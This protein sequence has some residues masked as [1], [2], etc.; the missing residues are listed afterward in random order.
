MNI[1]Y[2]SILTD[3][4]S[5]PELISLPESFQLEDSVIYTQLYLDYTLTDA[6]IRDMYHLVYTSHA[7]KQ[8]TDEKLLELLRAIIQR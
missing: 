1:Y 4:A 7:V 5:A 8:F 6:Q 2:L 3:I